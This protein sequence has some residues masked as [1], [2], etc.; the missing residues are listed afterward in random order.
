MRMTRP[1]ARWRESSW[2]PGTR[3]TDRQAWVV[4]PGL[5]QS[6]QDQLNQGQQL[7]CV[8]MQEAVVSDSAKTFGQD[9]LQD[10]PHEIVAFHGAVEHFSGTAVDVFEGDFAALIGDDAIFTD[11]APVEVA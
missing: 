6:L 9:M 2:V 5:N 7:L 11:D 3:G 8:A 10:K 1:I 4:V